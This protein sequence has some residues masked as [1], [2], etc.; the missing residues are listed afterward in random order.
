MGSAD[1]FFHAEWNQWTVVTYEGGQ[2]AYSTYPT[3]AAAKTA[4]SEY[5]AR[6]ARIRAARK[7][8]LAKS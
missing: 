2:K 8:K 4:A 5:N 7:A 6:A 3:E 1:A